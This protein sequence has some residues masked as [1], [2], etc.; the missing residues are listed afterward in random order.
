MFY[1][2]IKGNEIIKKKRDKIK[3]DYAKRNGFY[4]MVIPYTVRDIDLYIRCHIDRA[5]RIFG[6]I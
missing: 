1:G 6:C 3:A 2:I 5:K 4:F